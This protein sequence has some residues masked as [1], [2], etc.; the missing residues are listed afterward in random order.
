VLQQ[1]DPLVLDAPS[2]LKKER[3]ELVLSIGSLGDEAG[4]SEP[5]KERKKES[6]A[7]ELHN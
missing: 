7:K 4:V 2:R 6:I 1:C 3:E 5:K